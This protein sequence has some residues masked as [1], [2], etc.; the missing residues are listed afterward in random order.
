V[1]TAAAAMAGHPEIAVSALEDLRRVQPN[2]SLEWIA[3]EMPFQ[4][5]IERQHYLEGFR[6]AGIA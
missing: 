3:T 2:I 6:L 4:H 5:D 1:Y